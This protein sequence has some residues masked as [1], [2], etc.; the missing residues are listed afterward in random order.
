MKVWKVLR[1]TYF[2]EM[3][4]IKR[5]EGIGHYHFSMFTLDSLNYF[6]ESFMNITKWMEAKKE[7]DDEATT[8]CL[9]YYDAYLKWKLFSH[10]NC[11]L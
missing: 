9:P 3:D 2:G 1:E 7:N 8:S 6:Y 5:N 4:A 11:I 10:Y